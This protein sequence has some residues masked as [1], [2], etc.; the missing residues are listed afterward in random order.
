MLELITLFTKEK[1]IALL[2]FKNSSLIDYTF[3]KLKSSHKET[4]KLSALALSR[5]AARLDEYNSEFFI[6]GLKKFKDFETVVEN[7]NKISNS[8]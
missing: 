1:E 2:V 6:S 5:L 7:V 3:D 4:L 8:D